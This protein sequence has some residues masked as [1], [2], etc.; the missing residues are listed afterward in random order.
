MSNGQCVEAAR[1]V[2]GCIG[3]RDSQSAKGLVLRFE[4]EN[5]AAFTAKLRTSPSFKS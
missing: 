1:L 5:W 3:V 2:D 4:P